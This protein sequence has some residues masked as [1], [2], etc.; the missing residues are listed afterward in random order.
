MFDIARMFR[1][2]GGAEAVAAWPTTKWK[3]YRMYWVEHTRRDLFK[4]GINPDPP[5]EEDD[6]TP[7][8]WVEEDDSSPFKGASFTDDIAHAPRD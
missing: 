3:K 7:R 1:V 5:Q 6:D 8:Y 2:E 4:R